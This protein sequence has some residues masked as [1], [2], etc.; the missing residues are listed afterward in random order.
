MLPSAV[1]TRYIEDELNL[2]NGSR[3]S[4]DRRVLA[5]K[6]AAQRRHPGSPAYC[7]DCLK[8]ELTYHTFRLFVG[9]KDSILGIWHAEVSFI[10]G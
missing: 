6:G 10:D 7:R 1:T 8:H 3:Y 2:D 9:Y 4:K 5:W